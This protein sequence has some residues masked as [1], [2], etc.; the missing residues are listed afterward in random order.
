[1]NVK[2]LVCCHKQDV[3]ASQ[4]PYMPIHVGKALHP[5]LD[6]GIQ[7][8]NTGDNISE[9]N[10][11]YCEL[12]ALYWVWKNVDADYKGLFHY[13]RAFCMPK[14]FYIRK[15]KEHVQQTVNMFLIPLRLKLLFNVVFRT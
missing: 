15:I 4:E 5:E 10:P 3:M 8:D 1:M 11:L 12:T 14:D 2:I 9:K 13:R 6:L 7:G